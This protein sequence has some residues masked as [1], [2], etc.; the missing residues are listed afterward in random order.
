MALNDKDDFVR[1]TAT[2][3]QRYP[4]SQSFDL[5]ID[6]W[7]TDFRS[8]LGNIGASIKNNGFNFHPLE[9]TI[10]QLGART[11]PPYVSTNYTNFN[12]THKPHF[13]LTNNAADI[14]SSDARHRRFKELVE[15]EDRAQQQEAQQAQFVAQKRAGAEL[16]SKSKRTIVSPTH[17]APNPFTYPTPPRSHSLGS[18]PAAATAS[19]YTKRPA[20][21][22]PAGGS[23]LFIQKPKPGPRSGLQSRAGGGIQKSTPPSQLPKGLQ[24]SQKTQMLDFNAATEFQQNIND[25]HKKAQE[26][27]I[28]IY[29]YINIWN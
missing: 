13:K 7:S 15:T 28:Y 6:T 17:A 3:L 9:D 29:I 25:Q 10:L 24:R 12:S 18:I 11:T 1:T 14:I 5:N 4:E 19:L 27:K 22:T 26:G 8:L 2:I 16:Q 23:G 21:P 20:R